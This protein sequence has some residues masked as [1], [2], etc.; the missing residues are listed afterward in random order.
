MVFL[1]YHHTPLT[2][3]IVPCAADK[4][5]YAA[6]AEEL[7]T[8]ANFVHTLNAAKTEA[9]DTEKVTGVKT[10]VM[11]LSAKHGLLPL[12]TV[13]EPYDTKMGQPGSIEVKSLAAQLVTSGATTVCALLPGTYRDRLFAA[14]DDVRMNEDNDWI[15][16]LDAYEAA[17]GIGYQR[18]VAS[19]L[20][21]TTGLPDP[22]EEN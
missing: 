18:G 16:F 5:S 14:V 4:V 7:Y 11:I 10:T 19:S 12:D 22:V 17:P 13:V 21:R 1:M 8:S 3:F 9:V 15:E 20:N 2:V 6:P